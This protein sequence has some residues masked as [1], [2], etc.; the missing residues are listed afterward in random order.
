MYR[1]TY[2]VVFKWMVVEYTKLASMI[3][4]GLNSA[5]FPTPIVSSMW[6][7]TV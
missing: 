1:S 2:I 7:H 4:P 6:L 3:D 5:L